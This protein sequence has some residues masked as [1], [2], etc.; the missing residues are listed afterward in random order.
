DRSLPSKK[1]VP[2][3]V[4]PSC[5]E[6]TRVSS[7]PGIPYQPVP[8]RD[9][10]AIDQGGR[11]GRS[12]VEIPGLGVLDLAHYA[13]PILAA[14]WREVANQHLYVWARLKAKVVAFADFVHPPDDLVR[15]PAKLEH[16][17][18]WVGSSLRTHDRSLWGKGIGR[19][20]YGH[21]KA[22]GYGMAPSATT[23]GNADG[24]DIWDKL[25]EHYPDDATE[26]FPRFEDPNT[27]QRLWDEFG[28]NRGVVSVPKFE[29]RSTAWPFGDWK[30]LA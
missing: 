23:I 17:R 14:S 21:V 12:C 18:V 9:E 3:S 29:I 15:D 26:A 1:S 27:L 7:L 11:R 30:P 4:P 10:E 5:T 19:A 22:F 6:P 24:K 2:M 28:Q 20:L 8:F 25:D 16:P 13:T